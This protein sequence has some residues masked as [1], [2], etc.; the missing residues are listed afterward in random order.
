MRVLYTLT[1]AAIGGGTK[2]LLTLQAAL[3]RDRF[4]PLT[5]IPEAGPV[6]GEF[7]RLGLPYFTLPLMPGLGGRARSALTV[8]RLALKC[9]TQRVRILHANDP[10]TYRLASLSAALAGVP[11]VCHVHHPGQTRASLAW[12][13]RRPPHLIITPSLFMKREVESCLEGNARPR[14]EAVWNAVDTD[15]FRPAADAAALRARLGLAPEG[16]HVSVLAEVAPHKGHV[17]FLKAARQVRDRFPDTTFHVVGAAHKHNQDYAESLRRLAGELGIA[18]SV[19]FWGFVSDEAARDLLAL[20]DLFILPTRE[21]GFTLTAAEAQAC[22]VPV[23]TSAMPPLDEVVD[24]GSTGY[25]LDPED[26]GAFAARAVELLG[27]SP[28]R[29][30]MG[31]AGRAWVV[32]RFSLAAHVNKIMSLYEELADRK[33]RTGRPRAPQPAGGAILHRT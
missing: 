29:R 25:L 14:V 27:A 1:S 31:R 9:W 28:A 12:S 21:E 10:L 30:A 3:D 22:E 7:R 18:E 4:Q 26:P 23:L 6:E 32:G 17:C 5:V 8:A 13:F 19:R 16:K 2:V 24:D 15:W 20:S 33:P 11:R